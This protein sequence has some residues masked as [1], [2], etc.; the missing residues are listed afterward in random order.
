MSLSTPKAGDRRLGSAYAVAASTVLAPALVI[1]FLF[2]GAVQ[3]EAGGSLRL[4]RNDA[5]SIVQAIA[6]ESWRYDAGSGELTVASAGGGRNCGISSSKKTAQTLILDGTRYPIEGFR[7]EGKKQK[8]LAVS[9]VIS[10]GMFPLCTV[11]SSQSLVTTTFAK[12]AATGLNVELDVLGR[13]PVDLG[14]ADAIGYNVF[15]APATISLSLNEDVL[16]LSDATQAGLRLAVTDTNQIIT[17]Y[18]GFE[19][20]D[21]Q[22]FGG[23]GS[24]RPTLRAATDGNPVCLAVPDVAEVVTTDSAGGVCSPA[25]IFFQDGF[26]T[27]GGGIGG[28]S[29]TDLEIDFQL[30]ANP[31]TT[32]NQNAQYNLIVTNCGQNTAANVA[33]KDLY[34]TGLSSGKPTRLAAGAWSCASGATCAGGSGYVDVVLGSLDAGAMAVINVDRPL[35]AGAAGQ[36]LIVTA[37]VADLSGNGET[38]PVDNVA[39]WQFDVRDNEV[40]EITSTG[41]C[42]IDED[43]GI[44]D[45]VNGGCNSGG[46]F[47]IDGTDADG[48][49]ASVTA[50]S[51]SPTLLTVV[52]TPTLTGAGTASVSVSGLEISPVADAN[53]TGTIQLALIDDLGGQGTVDLSITV[54]AVNDAPSIT[55]LGGFD[56]NGGNPVFN[57]PNCDETSAAGCANQSYPA[58]VPA[59][60]EVIFGDWVVSVSPGPADEAGQTTSVSI[61][62][63]SDPGVFFGT[64]GQPDLRENGLAGTWDLDYVLSGN[65]GT[66]TV[67]ITVDDG[68]AIN[69]SS[70]FTFDILV[71]NSAPVVSVTGS[72]DNLA[73]EASAEPLTGA[74]FTV[75]AT[76]PEG[77]AVTIAVTSSDQ[78]LVADGDITID[79]SDLN[80][81]VVSVTTQPDAFGMVDLSVVASDGIPSAPGVISL[82]V[83][84]VNDAPS[85][86]FADQATIEGDDNV[87]SFVPGTVTL[88]LDSTN[89]GFES[90]DAMVVVSG[91]AALGPFEGAIQAVASITTTVTDPDGIFAVDP[92][93]DDSGPDA[94]NLD[95][96][97]SGNTGT[98]TLDIVLVDDGGGTD[99]SPT[100]TLTIITATP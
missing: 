12:G 41:S 64:S 74:G 83:D 56:Y 91:D 40:P 31:N 86:V 81:I 1:S 61:G 87:I 20:L 62:A 93:V 71:D 59:E 23:S 36:D 69:S 63:P 53:G 75:A 68:E 85:V 72:P 79:D 88:T 38:D 58:D 13:P 50:T 84:N 2:A 26:E 17:N 34:P 70:V 82:T 100:V 89:T 77:D 3:A 49:I 92:E 24:I 48:T 94:G 28:V 16:C 97:L 76:D 66:A 6:L 18:Q 32:T 44:S 67:T 10:G 25:D 33:V 4:A 15:A 96:A 46:G 99:T 8:L 60:F 35:E 39:S 51:L 30:V 57:G 78:T 47:T 9:P 5:G 42:T 73:E 29:S 19:S 65:S 27:G 22:P 98:A 11:P 52:G 14:I 37:S 21:Y 80:N 54:N 45:L 43:S 95:F 7:V 90:V 55:V